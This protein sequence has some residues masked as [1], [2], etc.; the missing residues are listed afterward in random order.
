MNKKVLGPTPN[1]GEYSIMYF[2]NDKDEP[3]DSSVA[4]KAVGC[5]FDKDGKLIFESKI[6]LKKADEL[7]DENKNENVK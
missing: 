5:E 6:I 2:Y 3:V 1:G 4:T 7:S